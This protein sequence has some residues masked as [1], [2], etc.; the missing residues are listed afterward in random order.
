MQRQLTFIALSIWG[1]IV[2]YKSPA[3]LL[4]WNYQEE[5]FYALKESFETSSQWVINCQGLLALKKYGFDTKI[6]SLE[7]YKYEPQ[8]LGTVELSEMH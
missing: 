7:F 4:G 2:D 5:N 1:Q 3:L 8:K 6:G